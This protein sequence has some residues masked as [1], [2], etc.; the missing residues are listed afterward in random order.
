MTT[1]ESDLIT[2]LGQRSW[3][4]VPI[5]TVGG[6]TPLRSAT[7]FYAKD[8]WE[9]DRAP[10]EC[11]GLIGKQLAMQRWMSPMAALNGNRGAP[12]PPALGLSER[13]RA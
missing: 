10:N 4:S 12:H 3:E 5:S 13:R 2:L 9:F 11:G 1:I 6:H 8:G 7:R